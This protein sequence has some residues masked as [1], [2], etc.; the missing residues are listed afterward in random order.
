M[1]RSIARLA[2]VVSLLLI[3]LILLTLVPSQPALAAA[4]SRAD[5]RKVS[6]GEPAL[7]YSSGFI[8]RDMPQEGEVSQITGDNQTTGNRR[9]LGA[10]D[11]IY[12]NLLK[13]VEAAPG[14]VFSLYRRVHKVFH[15]R[16]GRFM[17]DL[18]NVTGLVEVIKLTDSLATVRVIRSY[19]AIY[20]GDKAI[21]FAVP[22]REAPAPER[23]AM[24]ETPGTIVDMPDRYTLI[25]QF[26]VV[27]LDW[28]RE[29]G[30]RPG[31]RLEV[32]RIS[33][34][35][36]KRVI[37]ELKVLAVQDTTATAVV[38]QSVAPV[39]RG[40][41]FILQE[42]PSVLAAPRKAVELAA[43][44]PQEEQ[45]TSKT[46]VAA[47]PA[48]PAKAPV[49]AAKPEPGLAPAPQ[50]PQDAINE[51]LARLEYESG[52]ATPTTDGEDILRQ[53]SE[54][55]QSVP[56]RQA[57]VEGHTD[58]QAIGPKLKTRYPTNKELSDARAN[59]AVHIMV[60]KS[61]LDARNLSTFGYAD[62]QPVASNASEDGRK[63]NRRVTIVL[64]PPPTQPGEK[65]PTSEPAAEVPA[66]PPSGEPQAPT[67][68]EVAPST[69]QPD[70][71]PVNR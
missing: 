44:P 6:T 39:L 26:H 43:E 16:T 64:T 20:P 11:V 49:L 25:G 13:G 41:R 18:I 48:E 70:G 57:R 10:G 54:I 3:P 56:D 27:Y 51:L 38:D 47:T 9:A 58:S 65:A 28:G 37:A 23:R 63:K 71:G 24:P 30:L 8:A 46:E 14:D 22:P 5:L 31:D 2:C 36:P 7:A 12:V 17:G 34:G 40:D 29:D 4:A 55:L 33:S 67:P 21:P 42:G 19:N 59:Q 69:L 68:P 62:R 1:M 60:E 32:F 61:G 53:V 15:P 52:E 35:L 50:D 45:E 66:F